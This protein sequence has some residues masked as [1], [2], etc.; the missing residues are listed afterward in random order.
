MGY[1]MN[2]FSGFGNSPAKH[3]KSDDKVHMEL[4]GDKHKNADHPDHWK[5]KKLDRESPEIVET[6]GTSE[7]QRLR[8]KNKGREYK[9]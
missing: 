9:K 3:L 7:E 2:G 1:K 4:W 8:R 6:E 5:D